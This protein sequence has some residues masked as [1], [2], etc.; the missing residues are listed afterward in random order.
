MGST[1]EYAAVGR[2]AM[3]SGNHDAQQTAASVGNCLLDYLKCCRVGRRRENADDVT[4]V[5]AML[6][7][8]G[9]L[10]ATD[11]VV[12][13]LVLRDSMPYP[14]VLR[15]TVGCALVLRLGTRSRVSLRL[16]VSGASLGLRIELAHR[17]HG[18]AE[19]QAIDIEVPGDGDW[20]RRDGGCKAHGGDHKGG[21]SKG[22]HHL[23]SPVLVS[24]FER[25]PVDSMIEMI[26]GGCYA[27]YRNAY[28]LAGIFGACFRVSSAQSCGVSFCAP[29]KR[30]PEDAMRTST[31]RITAILGLALA[32]ASPVYLSWAQ[33]SP[34]LSACNTQPQ[35]AACSAV[36]G[37]RAEGFAA[38]SRAEVMATRGMVTT[39]QPLAAQSGLQVMMN[40]G[41]AIDAAVASAAVLNLV[42]PMNTGVGGDLFAII[43]VAKEKKLYT[44]NASGMAPTGATL[45]RFNA[46]GYRA[47]PENWGPGSGMPRY[48]ILTVTVPGTVWG[49]DELLR[50]FGRKTFREVLAPAIDY[51]E[52]GFPISQR[53]ANDW[54]LP[55]ALP[56]QK[57]CT[58]LDPDS[59]KNWY[60]DGKRPVAGQ[61]YRNPDLARTFRLLAEG[62]RDAFYKG[63][64]AR[65]IVK[66]SDALG[67]SMTLDDLANYKAEFVEAA[68]SNYRGYDLYELP[69]PSQAWAA[70]EMLNILEACVPKWAPGQTLA[71]LGP[72]DPKYWHMVVEAKKLA[73]RDLYK[74]NAD[75]NFVKIPLERLLSKSYAAS[76]CEGVNPDKALAT[77]P[78]STADL[79]DGDT[80]VLSTG[81]SEGN[82]VSWVNSNF[83]GFGSGLTVPGFGIVLHNR[84]GLFSLDPASPNVIAPRKRPFNTL[85][86]GFVMKDK[87]PVMTITL[88]GGDMQAQGH[89]QALVNVFDLG[90][91]LQ[92]ATDMARFR[93]DQVRNKLEME[94]ELYR[95]V[96]DRLKQMG[97]DV[98]RINGGRV[99]GYQSLMFVPTPGTN[100]GGLRGYYRAGSDHRKDGQAVGW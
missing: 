71:G 43:Y 3:I 51:A 58:E 37:D 39:S 99:G 25:S 49:W 23:R 81:D 95:L 85:A 42:E 4:G 93:H 97:H 24:L 7:V 34:Q 91:N 48:G 35:A 19:V 98:E 10:P 75:P 62:G 14:S 88:M 18:T 84:G 69:P 5:I 44:L 45:E 26:L 68:T 20:I 32:V 55:N 83:S 33:S 31:S 17:Q 77:G 90:A 60:I 21:C 2:V 30:C 79:G 73:Y 56:L 54:R 94:T 11:D 92:M 13:G 82:M 38:Q 46:L 47:D 100:I 86:A 50:R 96:G 78:R 67:G 89:A 8:V 22:F 72:R 28:S 63:E 9:K 6:P 76:L 36:R 40:G 74:F 12:R 64:I 57:C 61:I 66:K 87:E 27:R 41:N 29:Q 52:N 53:I 65:A 16:R 59:V 1:E 70:N 80:I 15:S